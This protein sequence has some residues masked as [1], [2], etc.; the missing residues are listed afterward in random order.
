MAS[1]K[2]RSKRAPAAKRRGSPGGR[3]ARGMRGR[4]SRAHATGR[5]RKKRADT[6]LE[7]IEKAYHRSLGKDWLQLATVLKRK[8]KKSLKKLLK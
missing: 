3:D 1:A 8:R 5:L 4:R 7:T 2:K 6:K